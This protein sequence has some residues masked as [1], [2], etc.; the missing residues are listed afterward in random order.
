MAVELHGMSFE[1]SRRGLIGTGLA[2]ATAP[3]AVAAAAYDPRKS[4][5]GQVKLTATLDGS[6]A[7]WVYTGVIYAVRPN[8]R[9]VA[10]LTLS[11]CESHWAHK[12]DDG[13]YVIGGAIVTFF[14][15]PTTGA[16]IDMF[17][18]P[19]TAARNVVQPNILSGGGVLYPADGS[20]ARAFGQIKSAVIAPGGFGK[21]DPDRLLGAVRWNILGGK[22]MLMTDRSW[23]VP[24]E[25]QLEAQTQIADEAAFFSPDVTKMPA[26]FTATTIMPWM[27]WLEMPDV[28]GH[29]AWHS[30]G[31]KVFS[32]AA[33][34]AAFKKKAGNLME[35]LTSRPVF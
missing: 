2:A 23:N 4:A 34:P 9:P 8:A 16:F 14:S 21:S 26:S 15:D 12:R 5:E 29:L 32:T 27:T 31:E 17:D 19:F 1:I 22:V 30:S 13:S 35:K 3:Q 28:P 25:P 10:I 20:S 33:I 7:F 6:P 24:V 18:N 11:G